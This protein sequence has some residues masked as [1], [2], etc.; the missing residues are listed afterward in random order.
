MAKRASSSRK[1]TPHTPTAE[2]PRRDDGTGL[3]NHDHWLEPFANHLR[4]RFAHYKYVKGTHDARGG[5]MGEIS[6]GHH[7]FGLNRGEKDGQP[8]VWYREWAPAANYL[9]LIGDFNNWDRGSHALQRD[10]W[11][12]WSIFLPDEYYRDRLT[13]G[14]RIKVHIGH[15][16]GSMDR[17]PAYIRRVVQEPNSP[18]FV[19][20]YWQPPE[21]FIW[22]NESPGRDKEGLRIYEA[23]VGMA[24][25]EGKV[26]SFGEFTR[27]I[28]PRIRDLGYNAIQ[29]MAI[30]EHPYYGSFG[31][32]VS[33]FYAVSSRFGTPD[34]LKELID[35][36]H[37]MGLQVIM[38]LVHSHAVK[39]LNEGL[40]YFDG[41]DYQYFHAGPRG[42]HIAWDSLCF[43]YSRYEV[44]RF[45]LSNVRF[46]L[47]EYR[48]DGFRFDGVTSM[49]YYDHGLGKT[50]TAYADYFSGNVDWDALVYLM[51]A[52]E[53]AHAVKPGAIT[54]AEDVSG[55]PG[56]ARP[57]S[58]GGVG[59][60]Y[61]LAMGVPDY[62]I[63]LL[64]E[65]SDEQWKLGDIYHTLLNRRWEEKHIGYVECHDQALVGD[66]TIAFRLMDAS[67]YTNMSVFSRNMVAERGIALHK[68]IRLVTFSLAGDG[69][70]NFMGNEFGHPEWIDFPRVGNN[71]S[72]HFA[73]RQWSLIEKDHL[74]YKGL[75]NFDRAMLALDRDHHI[76]NDPLIE[77]LVLHEDTHQLVYRRGPLV[78]V[79]NFHPTESVGDLR[80]PVPDPRDYRVILDTDAVEFD[81]H[82]AVAKDAMYWK[83]DKP[84]YERPQSI[85]IYLPARSAQV[86]A[87][88]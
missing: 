27:N 1:S 21:A 79:F 58:E 9:G 17:I 40:N 74:R 31:Y 5:L 59:F 16:A 85:Q 32:H 44:Q 11:G 12:A 84:M 3:I 57:T 60:D 37:G 53:V 62:W 51:M 19:G 18:N 33:N 52:N 10:E 29:L 63:K 66:Q 68:M 48:F 2:K 83:Q 36:A 23:H 86:L 4:D 28:L 45:L 69:Y 56:L 20:Q 26:G 39:N 25:E 73:R 14:S 7:H 70:L 88:V 49:L 55:L 30:M 64:K 15:Q 75:N 71:E 35:T 41:T 78:F 22:R 43:D 34:E 61:R 50:F 77:R 65:K 67:M 80:I 72:Y 76:L 47:E 6:Q 24:Q 42:Q 38:D 87:P 81:G 13:H 8:G 46:W 54:V 82:G